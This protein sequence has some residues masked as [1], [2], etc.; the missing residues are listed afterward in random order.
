VAIP[1]AR[2]ALRTD[3]NQ[4]YSESTSTIVALQG[5]PVVTRLDSR[6]DFDLDRAEPLPGLGSRYSVRWTGELKLPLRAATRYG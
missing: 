3:A 6:I 1:V 4:V 5:S 2:T